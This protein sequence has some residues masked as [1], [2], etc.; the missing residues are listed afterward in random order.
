MQGRFTLLIIQHEIF[1]L[2]LNNINSNNITVLYSFDCHNDSILYL[3]W[4][5]IKSFSE[6]LILFT[7]NITCDI[8]KKI[9]GGEKDNNN[10]TNIYRRQTYM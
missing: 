9:G 4:L 8:W 3:L 1:P 10:K 2:V 6:Y 5:L 7:S